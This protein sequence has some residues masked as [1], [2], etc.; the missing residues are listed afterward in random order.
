[1][2]PNMGSADRIIRLLLAA[3]FVV[4]YFTNTVTGTLGIA[5]L[6]LAVVFVFTSFISFCPLYKIFGINTCPVK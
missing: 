5:L 3:V 2:K 1:M 4:L 6:V